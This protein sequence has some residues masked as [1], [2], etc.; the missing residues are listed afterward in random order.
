MP[1]TPIQMTLVVSFKSGIHRGPGQL[2]ITPNTPSDSLM[3]AINVP[4]LFEGDEDRGI[5]LVIPMAFPAI[6]PGVYW[7][8]VEL[9]GRKFTEV[10]LRIVYHR[11]VPMAP[12]TNPSH[13]P[14]P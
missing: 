7:F 8:K 9:D 11:V 12:P 6:E 2:V 13:G 10:P 3:P 14:Q 4:V 1:Q 5:M